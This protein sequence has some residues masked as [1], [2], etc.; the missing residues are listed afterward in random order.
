MSAELKVITTLSAGW[1]FAYLGIPEEAF[2]LFA[3]LVAIDTFT[4]WIKWYIHKNLS[5]TTA[6]KGILSKSIILIIPIVIQLIIK[7]GWYDGEWRVISWFFGII[8]LIEGYSILWNL[9]EIKTWKKQT[10]FDALEAFYKITLL[11]LKNFI[12]NFLKN[13]VKYDWKELQPVFE[14]K[15]WEKSEDIQWNWDSEK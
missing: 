14:W 13:K 2:Y 3:T 10:E 4:W 7:L 9:V 5:S 6:F 8:S 12:E 15:Q 1:A 11:F